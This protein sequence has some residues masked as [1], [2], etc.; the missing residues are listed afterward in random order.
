MDKK[1]IGKTIWDVKNEVLNEKLQELGLYDEWLKIR[2]G[3]HVEFDR[4]DKL[5]RAECLKLRGTRKKPPKHAQRF[6]IFGEYV[7]LFVV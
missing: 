3:F 5:W 2:N 1:W 4:V 7:K 6:T